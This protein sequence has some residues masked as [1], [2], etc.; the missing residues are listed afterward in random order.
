MGDSLQRLK[1]AKELGARARFEGELPG[2]A[3]AGAFVEGG[4]GRR[5]NEGGVLAE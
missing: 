2:V 1:S 3:A 4:K 5:K